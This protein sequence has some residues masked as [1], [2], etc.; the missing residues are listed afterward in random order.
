MSQFV[1]PVPAAAPVATPEAFGI[2]VDIVTHDALRHRLSCLI[3]AQANL[4][5]AEQMVARAMHPDCDPATVVEM[6]NNSTILIDGVRDD[7]L[8]TKE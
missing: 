1:E 5:A 7:F 3:L 6:W 8:D 4:W 2:E